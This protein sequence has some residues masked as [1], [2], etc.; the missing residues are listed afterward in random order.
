LFFNLVPQAHAEFFRSLV[1]FHLS[2]DCLC[3]HGGVNP[4]APRIEDQTRESVIWG[5]EGFPDRYEGAPTV[6]Y[7]H[8]NNADVD[9][10]G[11]PKPR[12]IGRTVGLDTISHGVLTAMRFPDRRVF[13]SARHRARGADG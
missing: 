9:A 1:P 8:R 4:R 7:G 5:G 3:V 13:Q 12:I 10:G 2:A 11:W 6:V